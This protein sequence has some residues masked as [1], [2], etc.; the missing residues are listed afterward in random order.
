MRMKKYCFVLILLFI[1]GGCSSF[2]TLD[3]VLPDNRTKYQRG[4]TLP[5]LEIPPDLTQDVQDDLMVIPGEEDANTLSEFQRIQLIQGRGQLSDGEIALLKSVDEQWLVVSGTNRT[6]WP[7]LREFWQAKNFALDLDDAELG[8]ME[9]HFKDVDEIDDGIIQQEKFKVFSEAGT[10]SDTLVLFLSSEV[11]KKSPDADGVETWITVQDT[12]DR[13]GQLIEELTRHFRVEAP[14]TVATQTPK[15]QQPVTE[16]ELLELDDGKAYLSI[17]EELTTVWRNIERVLNE[18][19][20]LSI[21]HTD[22][23]QGIFAIRYQDADNAEHIFSL[24]LSGA[25]NFTELVV[26]DSDDHWSDNDATR[27]VLGLLQQD[28]NFLLR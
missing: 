17:P 9:T 7:G 3:E 27:Q 22:E 2:P 5:D 13:D 15:P 25:S 8:V 4:K 24:S 18:S 6:V 26:L 21:D 28:Y 11:Q 10:V 23:A 12:S 16:V 20:A 1:V 19:S 14:A